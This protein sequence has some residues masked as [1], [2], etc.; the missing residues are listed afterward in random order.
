MA[1]QLQAQK[2]PPG[3]SEEY[4]LEIGGA[5]LEKMQQ[6]QHVY[7]DLFKMHSPSR[8]TDTYVVTDPEIAKH[9]MVSNNKNYIKGVGI[10]RVRVLLGNGIMVSEGDYW[11]R[12]RRM[13][14]PAFHRQVIADMSRLMHDANVTLRER[15]S[16]KVEAG[17]R[18]NI[19]EETSDI[20]LSIVLKSIFGKDLDE[21]IEEKGENPF[22]VVKDET[23]RD[24]MF[25]MRFRNLSKVITEIVEKRKAENRIE[26]DFLSMLME[27]RDKETDENMTHKELLDEVMTL[28]VAGHETTA[29]ALNWAW[30]LISQHSEVEEKLV[31][32]VSALNGKIPSFD[33]LSSLTYTKQVIE[34][35]MRLYPPGWLLTRRAINDDQFG[36]YF[37][38][39]KTDVFICLYLIQ[40]NPTYWPNADS[41]NPDRF[42]PENKKD[43]HRFEYFPFAGGPRQCIG[44]YF[45]MVEM[46]IH[47]AAMIQDF[48]L[49]YIPEKPL[50]IEPQ[51]NLRTKHPIIM[52]PR[53]R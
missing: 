8:K 27:T 17:E 38:P 25:A 37:V 43:R 20:T 30:Y 53:K 26:M 34:E 46:Q 14:Q 31:E 16:S 28:I 11:K 13:I 23:S 2:Y 10:E 5:S 6:Y 15:W 19:T 35:T 18:I 4:D 45:A 1:D 44:D 24:L 41:F 47:L 52:L 22:D 51:I 49:E 7:G 21:L 48:S 42:D 9:V 3:P 36:E 29:S 32:E 33:D 39:A 40:R 50:E 12:Q